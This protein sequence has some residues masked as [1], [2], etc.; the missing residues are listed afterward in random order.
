[1]NIVSILGSPHGLAGNTGRLLELVLA[2]VRAEGASTD[3]FGLG[4]GEVRPCVAC[5]ACHKT[6][7]CPQPDIFEE[8]RAKI[9]AADG[10]ILAS[11]NYIFSVSAQLKAFMDR[12]CG[13]IH[14]LGFEGKYGAAV[15]TSGGGGDEPI[16]DYIGK[17]QLATGTRPIGGVHATMA[18]QPEGA[19]TE[20]IE[21]QA[22]Q[23]GVELVRACRERR[24]D[25]EV[26]R[27]MRDF[28][29]RMRELVVWRREEWPYEYAYWQNRHEEG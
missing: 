12:C 18:A 9:A 21:Q 1:L 4:A 29:A 14:C 10:V 28:R 17:F 6:G 20:G 8:L 23:L 22:R 16:V 24:T 13:T 2:G 11:P 3:T 25:P 27:Q 19:F 7:R 26:E 5:D 15:V